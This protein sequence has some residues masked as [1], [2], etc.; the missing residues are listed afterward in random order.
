MA[1]EK[2]EARAAARAALGEQ[3]RSKLDEELFFQSGLA[4]HEGK[5]A[6]PGKIKELLDRGADPDG[7]KVCRK[8]AVH[9]TAC[10]LRSFSCYFRILWC[11]FLFF[12]VRFPC[13]LARRLLRS[14]G[15]VSRDDRVWIILAWSSQLRHSFIRKD[16]SVV[17]LAL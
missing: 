3:E 11:R 14:F 13:L 16:P 17:L 10:L 8:Q 7:F 6:N 4:K 9:S 1:A 15:V 2:S 5:S 12:S